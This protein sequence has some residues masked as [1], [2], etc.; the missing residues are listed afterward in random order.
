[1]TTGAQGFTSK[2]PAAQLTVSVSAPTSLPP[3]LLFNP[4]TC[5]DPASQQVVT[6][7]HGSGVGVSATTTTGG[8]VVGGGVVTITGGS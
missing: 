4:L 5:T 7:A 1:M 6:V 2:Q 3:K 8:V